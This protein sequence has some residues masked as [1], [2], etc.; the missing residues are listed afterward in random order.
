[1]EWGDFAGYRVEG[2]GISD[3]TVPLPPSDVECTDFGWKFRGTTLGRVVGGLSV[4]FR[5]LAKVLRARP[6]VIHCHQFYVLPVAFIASTILRIRIVY[7]AHELESQSAGRGKVGTLMVRRI[8]QLCS[9]RF[10]AIITVCEEISEWYECHFPHLT[11]WEIYNIPAFDPSREMSALEADVVEHQ[12]EYDVDVLYIGR[13]GDSRATK[14]LLEAQRL[15]DSSIR[16][17]FLGWSPSS[18]VGEGSDEHVEGVRYLGAADHRDVVQIAQHFDV[19]VVLLDLRSVSYRNALPNK[20][21]ELAY[22][23]IPILASRTTAIE[24]LAAD[25]PNVMVV[26]EVL[27]NPKDLVAAIRSA[28]RLGKRGVAEIPPQ[29]TQNEM[30]R[31]LAEIYELSCRS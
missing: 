26:D 4:G 11:V 10:A 28:A 2:V 1:M 16:I 12:G 27:E 14:Y 20:F 24:R 31:R 6:D 22:S 17:S 5:M 13:T 9:T 21:W 7:D 15:R 8:E 25:L 23:G 30:V 29:Y 3:P 19:G 18:Q